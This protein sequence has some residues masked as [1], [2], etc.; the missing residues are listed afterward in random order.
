MDYGEQSIIEWKDRKRILG[1][2]ISFT[3]YKLVNTKDWSK[4][5]VKTGL[6]FTQ[7]EE[8]N[9]YRIYDITMT[10]SLG[11]KIFGVG[12]L[13]LYSKDESTPCLVLRHI[14]NPKQIR[15]LLTTKIEEEKVK[16]GLRLTEFN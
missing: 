15:N 10:S 16:R 11:E 1:M 4:I 7:E 3:R 14:K 6:L 13:V 8:V 12:T 9:L 5:F 2:P